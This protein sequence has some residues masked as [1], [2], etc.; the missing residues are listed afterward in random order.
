[1][2]SKSYEWYTP[3]HIIEAARSALGDIELDPCSSA[4]ANRVIG[5]KRYLTIEDNGL[6]RDWQ[7]RTV[8][9]NPPYGADIGKWVRKLVAFYRCRRI[10]RAIALLPNRTDTRWFAQL[11]AFPRC[12]VSGRLRFWGPDSRGYGATFPSVIVGMGCNIDIF[13][14]AFRNIGEIVVPYAHGRDD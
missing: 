14:H 13:A 8:Y 11:H 10:G 12:H 7:A 3:A 2:T 6:L 4:A 5:A 9:M 1:M